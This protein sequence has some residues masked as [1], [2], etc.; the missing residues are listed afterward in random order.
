MNEQIPRSSVRTTQFADGLPRR[1]WTVTEFGKL[2]AMG[3]F[4][5]DGINGERL[6]ILGGEIVAMSPKGSRHE[7]VRNTLLAFWY[8]RRNSSAGIVGETPVILDETSQPLP[9]LT[10]IAP[11]IEL[12]DVKA[13]DVV[14][15]VEVADTSFT[16]DTRLKAQLYAAAGIRDY[17]VINAETLVTT[18]FREPTDSGYQSRTDI[19]P[20]QILTPLAAPELALA[21]DEL[22]L[23][24]A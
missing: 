19:T 3:L 5:G 2:A 17:W 16:K 22:G 7:L 24:A 18:I 11:G 23:P 15:V 12:A 13:D 9:D 14:L 20:D 6:E 4:Q 8:R 21:L 1:S 10:I